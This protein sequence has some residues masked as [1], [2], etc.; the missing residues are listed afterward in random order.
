[1]VLRHE[2]A[3]PG[4][5]GTIRFECRPQ[6]RDVDPEGLLLSHGVVRPEFLEDPLGRHHPI[7]VDQEEPEQCP[8]LFRTDVD[9][10]AIGRDLEGSEDS[11]V[12][13]LPPVVDTTRPP[14]A[15][16]E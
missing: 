7:G 1:M 8:L 5:G 13:A 6:P 15:W 9:Q 11:V 3:A 4:A 16:G 14:G 10:L 2:D 12:Q